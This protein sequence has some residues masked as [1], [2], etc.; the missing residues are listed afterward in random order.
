MLIYVYWLFIS[1]VSETLVVT[2][3]NGVYHRADCADASVKQASNLAHAQSCHAVS[4]YFALVFVELHCIHHLLYD[5]VLVF[6][7]FINFLRL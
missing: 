7:S 5:F 4:E 2:L 6:V 3:L 1:C